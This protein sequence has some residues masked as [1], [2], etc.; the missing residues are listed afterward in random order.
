ML[1]ATSYWVC[2]IAISAFVL[3]F[4]GATERVGIYIFALGSVAT[5][6]ASSPLPV[7]FQSSELGVLAVDLVVLAALIVLT[8]RSPRIWPI[9]ATG[10]HL[11]AVGT[12]LVMLTDS[13]ILPRAYALAQGFWAYPMMVATVIGA[14]SHRRKLRAAE[15]R[16]ARI[17]ANAA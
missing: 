11:V 2:L 8:L 3:R 13:Q 6:P 10:F 4:G 16:P 12:H 1:L 15:R 9:W 14:V 17:P 7:R 5:V